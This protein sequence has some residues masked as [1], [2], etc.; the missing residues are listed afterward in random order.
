M[1]AEKKRKREKEL[2]KKKNIEKNQ[3][4]KSSSLKGHILDNPNV[5]IFLVLLALAAAVIFIYV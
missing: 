5:I 4:K 2:K 1:K 3:S